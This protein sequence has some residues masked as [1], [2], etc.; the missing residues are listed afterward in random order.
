MSEADLLLRKR[1][2]RN[3][4][5]PPPPP[6]PPPAPHPPPRPPPAPLP[7][8]LAPPAG[9]AATSNPSPYEF[10]D[11]AI[12]GTTMDLLVHAPSESL[13]A[14]AH[15]AALAEI[16]R[17]RKILSTYDVASDISRLNA[18]RDPITVAPELIEL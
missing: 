12:L 13:A 17:L 5:L 10:H 8:P 18:S 2:S 7:A 14:Q 15:A 4:P 1:K 3:R 6:P 16:E 11:P 9:A